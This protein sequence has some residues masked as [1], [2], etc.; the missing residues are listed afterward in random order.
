VEKK[1]CPDI[2]K[3]RG[4][5]GTCGLELKKRKE[6]EERNNSIYSTGRVSHTLRGDKGG[7]PRGKGIQESGIG[8]SGGVELF[9]GGGGG[10][11]PQYQRNESLLFLVRGERE[12][13]KRMKEQ[14]I[15]R[16]SP[17]LNEKKAI[18]AGQR[19]K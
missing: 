15:T 19:G 17:T 16:E 12:I 1:S 18:N 4:R 9:C 3:K 5:R 2:K 8:G 14:F 6:R 11:F 7:I 10:G 13:G